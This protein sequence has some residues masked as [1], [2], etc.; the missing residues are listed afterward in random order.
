MQMHARQMLERLCS[1]EQLQ[2]DID[3]ESLHTD[4]VGPKQQSSVTS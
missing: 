4:P 3:R 2:P 1:A